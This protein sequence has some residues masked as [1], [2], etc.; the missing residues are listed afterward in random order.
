MLLAG[1]PQAAGGEAVDVVD[2]V[3][4]SGG[5]LDASCSYIYIACKAVRSK[6]GV[7]A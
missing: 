4:G 3:P 2:Y 1:A 5:Q 7:T 6:G